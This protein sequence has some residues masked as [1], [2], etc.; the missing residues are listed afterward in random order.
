MPRQ[1][2]ITEIQLENLTACLTP[3]V[4]VLTELNDAFAPPFIQPISKT[5]ASL[6]D[7]VQNV[8]QNKKECAQLLENIHQ[9]LTLHKIYA[10]VEVQHDRN[11]IRQLF[12]NIEMN[13][14]L[15]D[16]HAELDEA[17]KVFEVNTAAAMFK[18]IAEMKKDVEAKHKELLELISTISETHTTSDSSS[19]HLGVNELKNSSNSFSLL[20]SKPKIFYGRE[21]ELNDIM[22]ILLDEPAPRIAILGG[23]MGK[24]SLARAVLHHS[25]TLTRFEKRF[26]VCAESANSSIGLAALIGLHVGLN[27]GPDLTKVVVP[28]FSKQPPYL[29]ILDNL[30]TVWEPVQ[31]RGTLEEFLSL[32]TDVKHLGLMITMR[33]T[34]RPAKVQWT[35]PFL[36]PLQPLSDN[37]ARQT[38]MDVTD[39]CYPIKDFSQLLSFTNNMPLAV[40][41]LAHLVTSDSKELLSL[42]SI[43]PNGL[44]DAELVQSK[45]PISNILSLREHIQQFLPP[46]PALVHSLRKHFYKLLDLYKK[47]NGEQMRLLV[48]QITLNLGNLQEVLQRG[49]DASD[50]NLFDTIYCGISLNSFYSFAHWGVAPVMEHIQHILPGIADHRIQIQFIIEVL[51]SCRDYNLGL[52]LENLIIQGISHFEHVYD[53]CLESKF[54]SAASFFED[55]KSDSSRSLQ[56][57]NKALQLAKLSGDSNRQYAKEVQQL[58]ELSMDLYKSAIALNLQAV[59]GNYHKSMAQLS[60]VKALMEICGM[61]GSS[62]GHHIIT[63][64]AEIH[65]SKSEYTQAQRIY[66]DIAGTSPDKMPHEYAAACANLANIDIQIGG[67]TKNIWKNLNIASE[68]HKSKGLNLG[69]MECNVFEACI[70]LR[71]H[72]FHLAQIKFQKSLLCTAE[73]KSFSLEQLADIK[74]WPTCEEQARWPVIHLSFAHQVQEKLAFHKALLFLGDVFMVNEDD[75]TALALYTVA[76]EGFIHMDVHRSQAQCMLRL[77][78]LAQKHGNTTAAVAHWQAARPLFERS[79]QTKDVAEIDSRLATVEKSRE[80]ALIALANLKAPD[81]QLNDIFTFEEPPERVAL[82]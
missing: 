28:Y 32:L 40:D 26:F 65:F 51:K 50:P 53:P 49:L 11:K 82:V 13:G 66:S 68:I 80:E 5:I 22:K 45:L 58:S 39:G 3:A 29:L 17:K 54:Y 1:S 71:E 46:S 18:N 12:R 63:I 73:L 21:T 52:Q 23:G 19:V 72:A 56:F 2:T 61:S 76:L 79:S 4:A 47:C 33:G 27:P 74:A 24:T 37:A 42:L 77:G 70:N 43:L 81:Q 7:L 69:I 38:F 48:G 25:D 67:P 9:V 14:L 41:L 64:Q 36:L 59:L 30:E 31:S 60:K 75:D 16:C 15:K 55:F 78:D 44:S 6:I 8:K 10:Y 35:R 20:P 34:T 62:A 57:A